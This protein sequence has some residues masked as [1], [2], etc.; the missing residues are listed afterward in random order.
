MKNLEYRK[1]KANSRFG[2]LTNNTS[3]ANYAINNN[4]LDVDNYFIEKKHGSSKFSFAFIY[5]NITYG[6]WK[7]FK[8]GKIFISND[9][10]KNSPMIFSTTL[11]N[12]TENTLFLKSADRKS[13][14]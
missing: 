7:D 3:Y 8:I 5:Q 13:V 11:D 2:K 6:V 9:F 4:F 14:V 10:V 12:H 1:V